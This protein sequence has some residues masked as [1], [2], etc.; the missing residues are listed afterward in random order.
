[1]EKIAI[2]PGSFDPP[3]EGHINII[4][5]ALSIFDK[6]IVAVG[7]NTA[8]DATFTPDERVNMLREIFARCKDVHVEKFDGL[9][10]DFV[11]KHGGHTVLR[12]IRNMTDYEYEH[13]MALAN[14]TL[15][16]DLEFIFMMT[17][18]KFAHLSSSIIKEVLQFGGAGT[19]MLH[20]IVEKRWRQK[21]GK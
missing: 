15:Y 5:R 11:R 4:K 9:L 20:P 12:G 2:C 3:T 16:P 1:M 14:K 17:E 8:K 13:Q 18:G 21:L 6:V 7:E 19:G 10:V